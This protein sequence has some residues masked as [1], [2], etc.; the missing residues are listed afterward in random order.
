MA[1]MARRDCEAAVAPGDYIVFVIGLLQLAAAVSYAWRKQYP[2]AAIWFGA[3]IIS[4]GTLLLSIG[5][6]R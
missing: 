5:P 2:Q 1:R 3:S 4:F 6:R